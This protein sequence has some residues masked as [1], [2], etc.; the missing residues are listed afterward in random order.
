MICLRTILD[1]KFM[2]LDWNFDFE[3]LKVGGFVLKYHLL[4]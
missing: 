4:G 2:I 3:D 1:E